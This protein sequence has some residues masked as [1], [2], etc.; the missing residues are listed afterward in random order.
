MKK[1]VL[2]LVLSVAMASSLFALKVP[3]NHIVDAAWLKANLGNKNLVVVDVRKN[4][5]KHPTYSVNHIKGAIYWNLGKDIKEGRYYSPTLKRPIPGY[6]AA[7]T[8]FEATMRRSGINNK[9]AVVF[10]SGGIA[11][12]DFRDGAIAVFTSQYYGDNNV[13]ILNGGFAG[14]VQAGGKTSTAVPTPNKGNFKI[15]KFDM[16][17]LAFAEDVDEAVT[18]GKI[19]LL[20]A[21]GLG[22]PGHSQY[23]GN[24]KIKDPRR[25]A[26]GHVPGAKALSPAAYSVKKDGVY[27]LDTKANLIAK[28]KKAGINVNKPLITYCNTGHLASGNWFAQ[29]YVIGMKHNR[30]Y[31]GSMVDYTA[32]PNRPLVMGK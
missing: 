5:K 22:K 2:T 29:Q 30:L 7:P 16:K 11:A 28:L 18:L 32:M 3:A 6:I 10:Y 19:Q 14:W 23:T 25:M 31:N 13:A 17:I 21:N 27:Y 1:T 15:K 12:K 9:T 20:D 4:T 24:I 8:K 26:E